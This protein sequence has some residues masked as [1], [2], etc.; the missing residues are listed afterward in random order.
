MGLESATYIASLD[1]TW[2][3]G[4]DAK[5]KGDDHVR[6]IKSVLKS[7]FANITGA[8]TASHTELNRVVGLTSTAEETNKKNVLNGYCPLDGSVLVPQANLPTASETTRGPMEVATAAEMAA[9]TDNARSASPLGVRTEIDL[10]LPSGVIMMWSGAIVNIP[11]K[12]TLCD[13][14]SGTPNLQDRFVVGAGSTYAVA[15]TG[16]AASVTSGSG[17]SHTHGDT[18]S[19]GGHN[20]TISVSDHT[21]LVSQMP[22]HTHTIYNGAGLNSNIT[23][24]G[25]AGAVTKGSTYYNTTNSTGGGGP[26][27][28]GASSG[29]V[30]SHTHTTVSA[31]AHTHA[32]ATLPPYY[33]LAYIMKL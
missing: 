27:N 19:A 17:G 30:A 28:H 20:H 22:A 8:V 1:A 31:G 2:P 13:G 26:H 23:N 21:L 12:W 6:L 18:G 33:A 25:V 7:S 24:G 9:G 32:A 14:T 4:A 10:H 5:N 11:A 3:L 16:G 15:A 29:I